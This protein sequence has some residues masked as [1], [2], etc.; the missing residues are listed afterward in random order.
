[1]LE[2]NR[3]SPL[4]LPDGATAPR[5]DVRAA[6]P[7]IVH[8]GLGG[9]HRAHLARYMHDLMDVDA[10]ALNWGIIGSGLRANDVPLLRAL[11][12]QDGLY[13]LVERDT[14]G[15]SKT[16]IGSIVGVID[17][18]ETTALLLSAIAQPNI[19]IVSCTVTEAGYHL[20]PATKTLALKSPAIAHDIAHPRMPQTLP[21]ILVE[22]Y[23]QRRAAGMKA[24]T[25]LTC[26]NIQHNGHVL[27]TA[28]LTLAE[29]T[30]ADLAAWIAANA[31]FP[32]SMVDR[33]TPVPTQAEIEA[34]T[35][36]TGVV[37]AASLSAEAFRQWV[38]EDDFADGRPDWSRVG[39]Q[40]V[41]DVAPY[42]A[43]KLRLLNG[44][45][46]AI[47]GAGALAGYETVEQTMN[48]PAIRRFMQRLMD[49]ETG[50]LLA[51]VPGIDLAQYKATLIA[52]FAN[53]AI[54]DTVRRINTDAP[55][56][57]LLDPLRDALAAGAPID[58]LAL[59][60]A[61]WCKRVCDSV[62]NGE[63][64]TGANANA[65]LQSHAAT[66]AED[67]ARLLSYEPTF[68]DLGSNPRLMA[69]LREWLATITSD[70]IAAALQRI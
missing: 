60:L 23:R 6:K 33:I 37:D 26:D 1:M 13:T 54:R 31:R 70:G 63:P 16:V 11:E 66:C 14:N 47:A 59:A 41:P 7:G 30:D 32:S 18:S 5:Y 48:D 65:G 52:R 39:A 55:I 50:P 15:E 10:S 68:G 57:L 42:E 8:I 67:P 38:I 53:P 27:R 17:A 4:T 56:N 25:A 3:R 62:A 20:D 58:L 21:G 69:A 64:I 34:L 44:S 61:A 29:Q 19:R 49:E 45:H 51:P 9:F 12:K 35:T 46:L 24:F 28:V 43:M 40:F 36:K 2:L 22:A